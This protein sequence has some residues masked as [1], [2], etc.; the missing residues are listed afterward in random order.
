MLLAK[1]K[2]LKRRI[3]QALGLRTERPPFQGRYYRRARKLLL[4]VVDLFNAADLPYR[5]DAGT[6]LGIVRDG[7]LIPWDN[8]IDLVLPASAVP[9]L[10]RLYPR[11]F[12]LGWKVSHTYRMPFAHDAWPAG[13]PR[14]I[15]I[16][17]WNPWL[18]GAGS[19]LMDIT[20]MHRHQGAY[21]WEMA[22]KVC[23]VDAPVFD[24]AE[25]LQY[26]DRK[27][28][29]PRNC[30]A[31]LTQLYGDWRTPDP[32]FHHDQFGIISDRRDA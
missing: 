32:T 29:V 11:I 20:I 3:K 15:K 14:V 27:L 13:A 24:D 12:L 19:T 9:R 2:R 25:T 16:R 4:D 5:L 17:S 18:F 7:D 23:R 31:Y 8:D 28:K 22:N 1:P 6:L 26:A 21:F 30:E 10:K